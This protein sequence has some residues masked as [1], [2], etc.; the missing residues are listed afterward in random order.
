MDGKSVPKGT[1]FPYNYGGIFK[2]VQT[3]GKSNKAGRIVRDGQISLPKSTPFFAAAA[4]PERSRRIIPADAWYLLPLA[5]THNQ[6][7]I[8][9]TPHN[10]N[11]KYSKYKEAWHLLMR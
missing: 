6:P 10:P 3:V 8:L 4:C 5:A 11:S 9:L 1:S 2:Y 7:G